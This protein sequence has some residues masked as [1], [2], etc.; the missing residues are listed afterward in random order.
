MRIEMV[1]VNEN[2]LMQL[3]N[4]EFT[5]HCCLKPKSKTSQTSLLE[6]MTKLPISMYIERRRYG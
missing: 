1:D 4:G 3:T 5:P 2:I 6:L